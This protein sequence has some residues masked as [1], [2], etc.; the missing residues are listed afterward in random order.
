MRNARLI[1]L[2]L[3]VLMAC[4]LPGSLAGTNQE[5]TLSTSVAATLTALAPASATPPMS[6][7]PTLE[8]TAPATLEPAPTAAEGSDPLATD[9]AGPLPAALLFLSNA[10][11]VSQIWRIES[12][13]VTVRQITNEPAPVLAFASSPVNGQLAYVSDND[14]WSAAAD[15]SGRSLLVDGPPMPDENEPQRTNRTLGSPHF[16][17]DGQTVAFGLGGV[18]LAPSV[19]GGPINILPSMPA[20]APPDYSTAGSGPVYFYTPSAWSP[21]GKRLLVH[22]SIWPEAGGLGILDVDLAQRG[23]AGAYTQV[24]SPD[25][26][27]CC[28]PVWAVDGQAVY[29]SSPYFGMLSAGLWR[30]DIASGA[31]QTLIKGDAGGV[32]NY[33]G[34]AWQGKDGKLYYFFTS[35]H[36]FTEGDLLLTLHR[37]EADG[38]SGRAAIRPD[39]W[40][41]QAALPA[42]DDRGVVI[43]DR[44]TIPVGSY[45]SF[46]Q[47]VWL[48]IDGGPAVRLPGMGAELAW[49]K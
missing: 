24:S 7:S 25:G 1:S 49:G 13:G 38:V 35:T 44:S 14:L 42:P 33:P 15:G 26:M 46:G 43:I 23:A 45:P 29:F 17:P 20:P 41:V 5:A 6:P 32:Y 21:D 27:A 28:S 47:L 10:S 34:F 18:N 37:S 11:G 3:L 48:P 30:A 4:N 12:D 2:L 19:G 16:S 22:Y 31:A 9:Q 36:T 39:A 40:F 8:A